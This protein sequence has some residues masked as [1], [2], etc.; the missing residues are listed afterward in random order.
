MESMVDGGGGHVDRESGDP[1]GTA[2]SERAGAETTGRL[3]FEC[4]RANQR[5]AGHAGGY[6]IVKD[7]VR[8]RRLRSREVFVPLAHDPGHNH[9][10]QDRHLDRR[11]IFRQNRSAALVEWRQLAA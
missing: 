1:G 4:D 2:N 5:Q 10:N 8:E 3:E 11:D 7:Y 9:F 6:T